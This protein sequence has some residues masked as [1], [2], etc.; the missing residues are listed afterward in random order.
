MCGC[1]LV[2]LNFD[3]VENIG[4]LDFFVA[5]VAE[6]NHIIGPKVTVILI[7]HVHFDLLLLELLDSTGFLTKL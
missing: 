5:H 6:Q 3:D 7:Q 2:I 4:L 1:Y